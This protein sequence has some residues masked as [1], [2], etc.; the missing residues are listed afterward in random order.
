MTNF[1]KRVLTCG[2][3]FA[4]SVYFL[5]ASHAFA[6]G[7][8]T[9][10]VHACV[11]DKSGTAKIVGAD[12]ICEPGWTTRHWSIQGPP[13]PLDSELL[14]RIETLEN[15]VQALQQQMQALGV[16]NRPLLSIS[17]A[18]VS[19]AAVLNQWGIYVEP[20]LSFTVSLSSP[21]DSIV[22]V[23]W[24]TAPGS[25]SNSDFYAGNGQ[26]YLL[27]GE[28]SKIINVKIHTD[29]I[30]EYDEEL[31]V[32][33]SSAAATVDKGV[34]TG[35]ILN[36]DVVSVRVDTIYSQRIAA[37]GGTATIRVTSYPA[38]ER[39]FSVRY[40]TAPAPIGPY[41]FPAATVGV[42]M[43]MLDDLLLFAA[44]ES[45]KQ[46]LV[47]VY[48]DGL[49]EGPE[50]FMLEIYDP[51]DAQIYKSSEIWTIADNDVTV[52]IHAVNPTGGLLEATE[53]TTLDFDTAGPVASDLKFEVRLSHPLPV[54][55][56]ISLH[57]DPSGL[58]QFV[59]YYS[60]YGIYVGDFGLGGAGV[61]YNNYY[62][63]FDVVI[64]ANEISQMVDIRILPDNQVEG[65]ETAAVR[66]ESS[67]LAT[68]IDNVALFTILDDD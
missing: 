33:I 38:S 64:P 15:Q 52:S 21:S 23:D 55:T 65:D 62:Q 10:I 24:V 4:A 13:G 54:S 59:Y 17:D 14:G 12:D 45:T 66:V 27:P 32:Y 46:I 2:L 44:G 43:A 9:S 40:R 63:N 7:G 50:S 19:E 68:G 18:R 57:R 47:D 31:Y 56:Q 67:Y 41:S 6:D 11:N 48:A 51:V 1:G 53:G 28:T 8:D 49:P 16:V 22:Y 36:D 34:G 3:V 37:E 25:A 5:G 30:F 42:D 60:Y 61:S 58:A 39:E 35:T 29:T 26:F 20:T